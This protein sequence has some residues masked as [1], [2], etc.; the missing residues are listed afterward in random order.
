MYN[1]NIL[2]LGKKLEYKIN[3]VAKYLTKEQKYHFYFK[4]SCAKTT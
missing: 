2:V 4:P 3:K 1:K